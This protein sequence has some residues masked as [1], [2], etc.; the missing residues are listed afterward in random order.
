MSSGDGPTVKS[1]LPFGL[2]LQDIARVPFTVALIVAV[3]VLWL[4][5]QN[6]QT[7]YATLA[8]TCIHDAA[9]PTR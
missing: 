9:T 1:V 2:T 3:V 4:T 6:V 5:L 8:Q 7:Q